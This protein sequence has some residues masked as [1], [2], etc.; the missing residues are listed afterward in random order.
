MTW[1]LDARVGC[2]R[3]GARR[4]RR[5]RRRR[6]GRRRQ[7]LCIGTAAKARYLRRRR[8]AVGDDFQLEARAE[9]TRNES[10]GKLLHVLLRNSGETVVGTPRQ[11]ELAC[12]SAQVPAK[13]A[14]VRVLQGAESVGDLSEDVDAVREEAPPDVRHVH[15]MSLGLR[16]LLQRIP[17]QASL[18]NLALHRE[19]VR[20]AA[21]ELHRE[22]RDLFGGDTM[23]RRRGLWRAWRPRTMICCRPWPP[24]RHGGACLCRC[25]RRT[26]ACGG[27]GPIER[28]A[29]GLSR[30]ELPVRVEGLAKHVGH[31]R[32]EAGRADGQAL[33]LGARNPR[34]EK[35]ICQAFHERDPWHVELVGSAAGSARRFNP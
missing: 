24:T 25:W 27:R 26:A 3:G 12:C 21:S 32:S 31:D 9:E 35:G 18:C 20:Y 6:Q 22:D 11:Q 19:N 33:A 13:G 34:A 2:G 7:R 23:H 14:V 5:W 29:L 1:C 28:L 17:P 16:K 8:R 10:F 4:R 30:G 15:E